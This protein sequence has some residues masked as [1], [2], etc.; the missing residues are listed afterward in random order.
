LLTHMRGLDAR[1][2]QEQVYRRM[3]FHL[4]TSCYNHWIQNPTS[5]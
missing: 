5:L 3:V 1:S 2:A 4:C